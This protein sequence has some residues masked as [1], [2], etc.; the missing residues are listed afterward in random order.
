V[1]GAS[2]PTAALPPPSTLPPP[3]A[4]AGMGETLDPLGLLLPQPSE[5][6]SKSTAA[7]RKVFAVETMATALATVVPSRGR[8]KSSLESSQ[9]VPLETAVDLRRCTSRGPP[10]PW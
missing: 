10:G 2:P 1:E 5:S 3:S 8:G 9:R 4:L 7:R 6:G